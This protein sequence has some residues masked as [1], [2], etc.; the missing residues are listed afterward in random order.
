[1]SSSVKGN[2]ADSSYESLL[3]LR[4]SITET[5]EFFSDR[6]NLILSEE[7]RQAVESGKYILPFSTPPS[8]PEST[9][10]GTRMPF[11]H[12][13]AERL[14][15]ITN[16]I[17]LHFVKLE[18]ECKRMGTVPRDNTAKALLTCKNLMSIGGL[19][20][21][22]IETYDNCMNLTQQ[23]NVKSPLVTVMYDE[24]MASGY[25]RS[26]GQRRHFG[27]PRTI[28][29]PHTK[30][31]EFLQSSKLM[32]HLKKFLVVS[33]IIERGHFHTILQAT[34]HVKATTPRGKATPFLRVIFL[35]TW[36]KLQLLT[37]RSPS[38]TVYR[39]VDGQVILSPIF[40]KRLFQFDPARPSR[41]AVYQKL[42]ILARQAQDTV[43]NYDGPFNVYVISNE[44]KYCFTLANALSSKCPICKRHLR[45]FLPPTT[46]LELAKFGQKQVFIHEECRYATVNSS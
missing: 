28:T 6:E 8:S 12:L 23:L 29:N 40:H 33:S 19:C 43:I 45:N 11:V 15:K 31:D 1:M 14:E 25:I 32:E 16:D 22:W 17:E 27:F 2:W 7:D 34:Y 3:K 44:I 42:S 18:A 10:G 13:P 38:E 39:N 37:L 5:V 30:L 21:E 4:R 36:G 24:L 26:S 20:S 9:E 46:T 35:Y 41:Y